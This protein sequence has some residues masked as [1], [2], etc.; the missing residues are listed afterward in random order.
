MGV[1]EVLKQRLEVLSEEKKD[2]DYRLSLVQQ[3]TEMDIPYQTFNKYIKGAAE[4]PIGNLVKIAKYYSVSTDYLLGLTDSRAIDDL[5]KA[6]CDYT[7]LSDEAVKGIGRINIASKMIPPEMGISSNALTDA[8]SFL[9]EK[10]FVLDIVT[11]LV[12]LARESGLA[13]YGA[14]HNQSSD[15]TR[16]HA[17]E[18]LTRLLDEFD[19]RVSERRLPEINE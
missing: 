16:Y 12:I 2:E 9:F 17:S 18:S 4:C 14:T 5:E 6:I 7:G 15:L 13:P 10:Q 3:A 19:S 8:L 1:K 11:N